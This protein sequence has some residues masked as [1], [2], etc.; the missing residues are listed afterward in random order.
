MRERT[1]RATALGASAFI[2]AGS[3]ALAMP[4]TAAAAETKTAAC[5]G[6]VTA[7]TGDTILGKTPLLGIPLNLGQAGPV[8][9]VLTGTIN[10]LLGT[11]CKVTVTVVNTVVAPVPVVGEPAAEALNGA[12]TGTTQALTGGGQKAPGAQ[13]APGKPAPGTGAPQQGGSGGTP[14]QG[15]SP[16][17]GPGIP[18]AN[19]PLLPGTFTPNFGGLPWG[20]STGYAPMRDYSSIPM[21]TAGLFSPSP[22]LRYGSQIPGYAPQFGIAAEGENGTANPD[23]HTAGQAE[24]LPNVSDGFTQDG[25]LPLLLAVLALS[26]VSAGLVRT[27]V[28]RRMAASR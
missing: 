20:I 28:L 6:S 26:G 23:V 15:G 17:S 27:W 10:A 5:G 1:R 25:K 2:L 18:A 19:S 12:V 24:A 13:P 7:K 3:A 9:G 16:A 14:A 8:S 4:G 22:G 11:V 21:A